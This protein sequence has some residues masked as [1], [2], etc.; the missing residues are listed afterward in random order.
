MKVLNFGSMH[1]DHVYRIS[2]LLKSGDSAFTKSLETLPGGKGVNQSIAIKRAGVD[3]IHAGNIG[4]DG[5]LI[6]YTL[7]KEGINVDY[8][9]RSNEVCGHAIIHRSDEKEHTIVVHSGASKMITMDYIDEVF[10]DFEKEDILLVQGELN[11]TDYIIKSAVEKGMKCFFYPAPFLEEFKAYDLSEIE[12]LI[13]HENDICTLTGIE[14][15]EKA[16]AYYLKKNNSN[17]LVISMNKGLLYYDKKRKETKH[18]NITMDSH[19]RTYASDVLIGYFI[20]GIVQNLPIKEI[21]EKAAS[22]KKI[23]MKDKNILFTIPY[24]HDVI[25]SLE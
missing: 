2:K 17:L 4:N 1:L 10:R 14:E 18:T 11:H 7:L 9:K 3:V 25:E 12:T 22:A 15:E 20:A 16:V 23:A 8:V 6:Y 5:E 19:C 21:L 13:I 24:I